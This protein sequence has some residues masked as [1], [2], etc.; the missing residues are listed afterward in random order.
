LKRKN[1]KHNK[2]SVEKKKHETQKPP[3]IQQ[4]PSEAQ[5]PEIQPSDAQELSE[6]QQFVTEIQQFVTKQQPF[7][8]TLQKTYPFI[9]QV[10]PPHTEVHSPS[11]LNQ[12]L[13]ISLSPSSSPSS[14]SLE[15]PRQVESSCSLK[16]GTQRQNG[17]E[18]KLLQKNSDVTV[19]NN[20]GEEAGG[21]KVELNN[22]NNH[23]N[24]CQNV[25]VKEEKSLKRYE[26]DKN[27]QSTVIEEK[28]ETK[29]EEILVTKNESESQIMESTPPSFMKKLIQDLTTAKKNRIYLNLIQPRQQQRANIEAFFNAQK[30]NKVN[31]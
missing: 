20:Y 4:Q 24:D 25:R 7:E 21:H 14:H 31:S 10:P 1:K 22:E 3:E 18:T 17:E 13:S 27:R 12:S 8:Y 15:S 2:K 5:Q 16:N 26:Y 9:S 23:T 19:K 30:E 6:I 29:K 11:H 28:M